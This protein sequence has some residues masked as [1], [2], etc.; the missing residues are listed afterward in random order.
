[1]DVLPDLLSILEK[2]YQSKATLPIVLIIGKLLAGDDV[3]TQ[4]CLDL[5]VMKHLK[6]LLNQTEDNNQI[7]NALLC[8]S[9]IAAGNQNQLSVLL[10]CD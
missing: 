9:N 1:M 8:F 4:Y 3:L 7:K 10:F 6:T 2:D 5:S